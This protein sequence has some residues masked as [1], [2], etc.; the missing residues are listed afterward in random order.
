MKIELSLDVGGLL[1]HIQ[2]VQHK[3]TNL[4]P[5]L[6]Q[7]GEVIERAV[8]KGFV[9]ETTPEGRPWAPLKDSTLAR[10]ARGG[11]PLDILTRTRELRE[12]IAYTVGEDFVAVGTN[13]PYGGVHMAGKR[14]DKPMPARPF[15]GL[16]EGGN[17]ALAE[18][19]LQHLQ[20]T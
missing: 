10:K 4:E 14:G 1:G 17:R 2:A 3:L 9:D 7:M 13:V 5:A 18:V 20:S 16:P 11:F 15:L 12:S 6:Q 8:Q 19:L